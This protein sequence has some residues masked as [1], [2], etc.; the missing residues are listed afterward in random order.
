MKIIKLL[1]KENVLWAYIGKEQIAGELIPA[2]MTDK[3]W[4]QFLKQYQDKFVKGA[5]QIAADCVIEFM[6]EEDIKWI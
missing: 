5:Y 4:E 1:K 2:K 6:E 3:Q